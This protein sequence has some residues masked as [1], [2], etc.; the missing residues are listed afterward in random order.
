MP[1]CIVYASP[2][3]CWT[4]PP[5]THPVSPYGC[6]DCTA[7]F[8]CPVGSYSSRA[9]ACGGDADSPDAATFYCPQGAAG[10]SIVGVGN[11]SVGSSD[12]VL[13]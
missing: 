5:Y 2:T 3:T 13:P 4:P 7:G 9:V 6:V 12:E 10:P 1:G 8:Y 11:Y